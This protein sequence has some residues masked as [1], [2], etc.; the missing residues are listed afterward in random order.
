MSNNFKGLILAAGK[1]SRFQAES[2]EPFPKVLR[3]LLGKPMVYYVIDTLVEVGVDDI[4]L[5]VGYRADDVKQ[6]I[7]SRASYVLQAEQKGSGHAV[8]CAKDAFAGFDGNLIIMCG[9]SPLFKSKTLSR[10][11]QVHADTGAVATL[12]AAILD[13]PFGYGRIL[14]D[15]NGNIRGIVEEKCAT[16]E[17]RAIK[18]V[19]GGAYIFSAQWL[20]DN[21]GKMAL[22]EAGEYNLTDMVRVALEQGKIVSSVEC[23]RQE[24][25]GV[26]TPAQLKVVE[27]ILQGK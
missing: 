8:A 9:D 3:S 5:I 16:P 27:D 24:L 13:D 22:N 26:N 17:Q 1:G 15:N 19:N 12:A 7:G 21:I 25:L 20:F 10:M 2:G 23:D 4:T 6:A 18:E 11:M 14:R